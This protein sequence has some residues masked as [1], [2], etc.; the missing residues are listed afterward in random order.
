MF[1]HQMMLLL[2]MVKHIPNFDI[3][4]PFFKY[5]VLQTLYGFE[6]VERIQGKPIIEVVNIRQEN[7]SKFWFIISCPFLTLVT[8]IKMDSTAEL[9]DR[10][11]I[12]SFKETITT[13]QG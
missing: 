6:S 11:V 5:C 7:E 3:S 9:S 4:I 13:I 12:I 1:L 10:A 2:V 8:G